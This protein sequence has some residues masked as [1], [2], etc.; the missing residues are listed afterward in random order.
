MTT[1]VEGV[2]T[3]GQLAFLNTVGA[4]RAQGFLFSE[5]IPYEAIIGDFFLRY[6]PER[7]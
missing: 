7:L 2:E 6:P 4:D 3:E 5:P 1:L